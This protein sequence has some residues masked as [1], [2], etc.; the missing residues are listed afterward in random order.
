MITLTPPQLPLADAFCEVAG[1]FAWWYV[2]LVDNDGNGVVFIAGFALPFLPMARETSASAAPAT[3]RQA[4]S[5]NL[6]VYE[7]GR[8]VWYALQE[9]DPEAASTSSSEGADDHHF[10]GSRLR[11]R[12]ETDASGRAR[13]SVDVDVD[14]VIDGMARAQGRIVVEGAARF[15]DGGRAADSNVD[16][17][18][19]GNVVHDWSPQTGPSRGSAALTL[20]GVSWQMSGRGYHDRN[21]SLLPLRELG[22]KTWWW[23]RL[24]SEDEER[25]VYALEPEVPAGPEGPVRVIGVIVDAHG[26]TTHREDLHFKVTRQHRSWFGVDIVDAV[27]I[28]DHAGEVF[29]EAVISDVL[30]SGPFYVRSLW[31]SEKAFGVFEQVQPA[32]IGLE[33]YRRLVDMRVARR[34]SAAPAEEAIKIS[35]SLWLPLF[36]GSARTRFRRLARCWLQRLM[37]RVPA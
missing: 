13:I 33:R 17:N 23:G 31:R 26:R 25:I 8:Q 21:G 6:A 16:G 14:I 28:V 36:C 9:L 5:V 15:D 35:L 10:G 20:D 19:G 11:V 18:V 1:G 27:A 29:V 30:E 2:D 7:G 32:R 22:I 24:S 4:P 37:G 12:R 3:P 34:C